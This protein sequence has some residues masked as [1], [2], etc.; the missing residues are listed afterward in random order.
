[1][2]RA[3]MVAITTALLCLVALLPNTVS[4]QQKSLK[5]ELVGTW[6]LQSDAQEQNGMKTEIFGPNPYGCSMFTRDGHFQLVSSITTFLNS[7][8]PVTMAP[9]RKTKPS[10]KEASA[11]SGRTR[12]IRP[13]RFRCASLQ[14]VSRTG[15]VSTRSARSKSR[16]TVRVG[17]FRARRSA[18]VP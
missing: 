8:P 11:I 18:V 4:A 7:H 2:K 17:P 9:L 3:S 16:V 15:I 6:I 14:A 13:T 5:D 12:S 10:F 1:M